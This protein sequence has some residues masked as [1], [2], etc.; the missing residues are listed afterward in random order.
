[1]HLN[2]GNKIRGL[3][4]LIARDMALLFALIV[5]IPQL[6][7]LITQS[8]YSSFIIT[9]DLPSPNPSLYLTTQAMFWLT[10]SEFLTELLLIIAIAYAMRTVV[11]KSW[12]VGQFKYLFNIDAKTENL[13][14]AATAEQTFDSRL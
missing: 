11:R 10:S 12:V 4:D 2:N 13:C 9:G 3:K 8:I 6:F 14:Y 5:S 7:L 1:M